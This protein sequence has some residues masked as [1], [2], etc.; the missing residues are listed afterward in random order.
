MEN[1]QSNSLTTSRC[2]ARVWPTVR[3]QRHTKIWRIVYDSFVLKCGDIYLRRQ[4]RRYNN[5][6]ATH[7]SRYMGICPSSLTQRCVYILLFR[8]C[9]RSVLGNVFHI[10]IYV[11]KISRKDTHTFQGNLWAVPD[12]YFKLY[13]SPSKHLY[14]LLKRQEMFICGLIDATHIMNQT[15]YHR[16]DVPRHSN[17]K[18]IC[19]NVGV[20]AFYIL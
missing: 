16:G 8:T 7:R 4:I 18:K 6:I 12:I 11:L 14:R 1:L 20:R 9:A 5:P 10:W 15:Q 19:C 17:R 2:E 13:F 3:R